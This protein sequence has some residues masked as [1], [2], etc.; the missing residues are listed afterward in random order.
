MM[1]CRRT[2]ANEAVS[3]LAL[4]CPFEDSSPAE[5]KDERERELDRDQD[6]REAR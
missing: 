6:D 2:A 4:Q 5:A 3:H 1:V